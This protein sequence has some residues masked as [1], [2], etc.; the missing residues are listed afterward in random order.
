MTD[1][2]LKRARALAAHRRWIWCAGMMVFSDEALLDQMRLLD[3]Y[4][5]G[6]WT[7]VGYEH[8]VR[9]QEVIYIEGMIPDLTDALTRI[10][11][12]QFER[13]NEH[14]HPPYIGP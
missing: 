10:W 13:A 14:A 1:E 7:C 5:P 11:C 3:L 2:Q 6:M 9:R 4:K 12:E 8:H